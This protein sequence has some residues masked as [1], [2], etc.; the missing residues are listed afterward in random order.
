MKMHDVITP[1]CRS[2]LIGIFCFCAFILPSHGDN[3]DLQLIVGNPSNKER[4][5]DVLCE[6]P[7]G[8]TP[9]DILKDGGLRLEY[10]SKLYVYVVRTNLF[11]APRE[12]RVF[13]LK[14]K[15]EA[16]LVSDD[17]AR[18]V[19]DRIG[20]IVPRL[21]A[22][23]NTVGGSRF[24]VFSYLFG[25]SG[26]MQEFGISEDPEDLKKTIEAIDRRRVLPAGGISGK[27]LRQTLIDRKKIASLESALS[28]LEQQLQEYDKDPETTLKTWMN[29]GIEQVSEPQVMFRLLPE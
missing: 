24:L 2:S 22:I 19:R 21:Y 1:V 6:L 20:E 13:S 17:R 18:S 8:L 11:L 27:D 15:K 9:L 28:V 25:K 29:N 23:G 4:T 12:T 5:L 14:I 16:W 26:L 3:V 10:D 7:V